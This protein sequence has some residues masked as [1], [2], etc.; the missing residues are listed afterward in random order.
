MKATRIENNG[1][2]RARVA[3][4]NRMKKHGITQQR[5]ESML[6]SQDGRCAICGEHMRLPCID[7]DHRSGQVR[8]LLCTGCNTGIGDLKDDPRVVKA[9]LDY[10]IGWATVT[11]ASTS[12]NVDNPFPTNYNYG[13]LSTRVPGGEK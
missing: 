1:D 2:K 10:L 5:F 9:A 6:T 12:D 11:R 7:H 3:L 4:L 13:I 8:G